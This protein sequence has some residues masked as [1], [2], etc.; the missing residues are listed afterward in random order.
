MS[1]DY[2]IATGGFWTGDTARYM[3]QLP[4]EIRSDVR[5]IAFY[6]FTCPQSNMLGLYYLNLDTMASETAIEKDRCL[7]CMR[8]L[9]EAP[10]KDL[11][12]PL[13]APPKDLASPFEGVYALYWC[14]KEA[15]F[16]PSMA[17]IQLQG[18]VSKKDNR[19]KALV[20]ELEK[21]RK[22]PFFNH[23]LDKY[24]D[25]FELHDVPRHDAFRRSS[26]APSKVLRRTYDPDPVNL[27]D[28]DSSDSDLN[29]KQ[30]HCSNKQFREAPGIFVL[31]ESLKAD[32]PKGTYRQS[33][34]VAAERLIRRVLSEQWATELELKA[35]VS[36]YYAQL[37]A[38]GKLGTQ[39]V[40]SPSKFFDPEL[41]NW[42]EEFP[43]PPSAAEIRE[44]EALQKLHDRRASIGIPEFRD[45]LPG[46][47]SAD[48]AKAQDAAWQA[49]KRSSVPA[50]NRFAAVVSTLAV[51]KSVAKS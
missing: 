34:W 21:H 18:R 24:L 35:G 28:L 45:A 32:Y 5:V 8:I 48:Y 27:K 12:S 4:R 19:H 29:P 17:W 46:E 13:E 40:M 7:E 2:S 11:R 51:G 36:R 14:E 47:S 20:K 22:H 31:I 50:D 16:L 44:R 49:S 26:E 25:V 23:F 15:V 10:S 41:R 38:L 30:P 6:L 9:G 3:R 42:Q 39:Y 43:V 1:R 37:V 33:E